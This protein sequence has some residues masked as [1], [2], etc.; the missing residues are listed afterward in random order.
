LHKGHAQAGDVLLMQWHQH[1]C[2]VGLLTDNRGTLTVIHAL[3]EETQRVIEQ[4]YADP[5]P[6]RVVGVFRP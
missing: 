3:A 4:R 2:H 6:R 5:W 1:P